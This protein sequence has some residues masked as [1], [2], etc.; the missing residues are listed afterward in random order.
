MFIFPASRELLICSQL[1]TAFSWVS[2][3]LQVRENEDTGCHYCKSCYSVCYVLVIV[4]LRDIWHVGP[5]QK[6]QAN[7]FHTVKSAARPFRAEP[8][9]ASHAENPSGAIWRVNIRVG[10]RIP[11]PHQP[12]P[13]HHRS[14]SSSPLQHF[15]P[16]HNRIYKHLSKPNR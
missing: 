1:E 3:I 13:H 14:T 11:N 4:F 2:Q 15:H 7:I 8:T 5:C 10:G 6:N 9:G 16:L 12:H